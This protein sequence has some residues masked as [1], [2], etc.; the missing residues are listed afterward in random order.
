MKIGSINSIDGVAKLLVSE[1]FKSQ[2]P[3]V[4]FFLSSAPYALAFNAANYF[5]P[6]GLNLLSVQLLS[7]TNGIFDRLACFS[8]NERTYSLKNTAFRCGVVAIILLS[9]NY[10]KPVIFTLVQLNKILGMRLACDGVMCL[11]NQIHQRKILERDI[12]SKWTVETVRSSSD[13]AIKQLNQWEW[14]TLIE[15]CH[16]D[17]LKALISRF[18]SMN[19]ALPR[20]SLFDPNEEESTPFHLKESSS[21]YKQARKMT[22][23]PDVL[24]ESVKVSF[25][26]LISLSF[27][28]LMKI[29]R[30]IPEIKV[31]PPDANSLPSLKRAQLGWLYLS[32]LKNKENPE[33][34]FEGRDLAFKALF[35]SC[36]KET[37]K[38]GVS[39]PFDIHIDDIRAINNTAIKSL[40]E[41]YLDHPIIFMCR[42][43]KNAQKQLNKEFQKRE[44]DK[45]ESNFPF[46]AG[47]SFDFLKNHPPMVGNLYEYFKNHPEEMQK[48]TEKQ[49]QTLAQ[50]GCIE[51]QENPTKDSSSFIMKLFG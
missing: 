47:T 30:G 49:K 15:T 51:V 26:S 27:E 24:T 9:G 39:F 48:L 13:E 18:Y 28:E 8:P 36:F 19:L 21:L 4:N 14:N 1:T 44:L 46:T 17:V 41:Y 6:I 42:L 35:Y 38:E 50:H 7:I 45:L 32:M 25:Q 2:S 31:T 10:F 37:F 43:D 5:F 40:W 23:C 20:F 29:V 3:T 33:F 16:E 11:L 22:G 12:V 34:N